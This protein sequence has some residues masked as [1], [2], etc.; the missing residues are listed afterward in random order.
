MIPTFNNFILES[1]GESGLMVFGNTQIDNNLIQNWL[2][3][4]DYHAEWH[5][6]EGFWFFPENEDGY[7]AL[8]AELED[9]FLQYGIRARF[10]G[11]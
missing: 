8:E 7:D 1:R 3:E 10:E 4:S 2:E 6:R 5:S 9:E 11:V